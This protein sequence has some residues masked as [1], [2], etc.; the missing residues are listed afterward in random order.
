M[1]NISNK[2]LKEFLTLIH[3]EEFTLESEQ[4]AEA[5]LP[6]LDDQREKL[7]EDIKTTQKAFAAKFNIIL[8]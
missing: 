6:I 7:F 3:G 4:K 8:L 1:S 5:L 2:E